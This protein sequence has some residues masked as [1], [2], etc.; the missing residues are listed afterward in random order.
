[1]KQ[2]KLRRH[3]TP[4]TPYRVMQ[5]KGG[6]WVAWHDGRTVQFWMPNAIVVWLRRKG[7]DM[8]ISVVKG[9]TP[10]EA[11]SRLKSAIKVTA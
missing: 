11:L 7:R 5:L 2:K 6:G 1:M 9:R 3:I 10:F 4:D 8:R